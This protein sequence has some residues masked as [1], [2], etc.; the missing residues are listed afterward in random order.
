MKKR[1]ELIKKCSVVLL[2]LMIVYAVFTRIQWESEDEENVLLNLS[3]VTSIQIELEDE[4]FTFVKSEG[5]WKD[6]QDEAFPLSSSEMEWMEDVV[7]NLNVLKEFDAQEDQ[8]VYGLDAPQAVVTINESVTLKIGSETTDSGMYVSTGEDKVYVISKSDGSEFIKSRD[9][10]IQLNTIDGISETALESAS[11]TFD[12]VVYHF[13][14]EVKTIVDEETE[15]ESNVVIW[16][17]MKDE[18]KVEVSEEDADEIIA[19]LDKMTVDGWIDYDASEEELLNYGIN[20]KNI[21]QV[22]LTDSQIELWLGHVDENNEC[23]FIHRDTQ[24]VQL[25][26]AE[27]IDTMYSIVTSYFE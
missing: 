2:G 16:T 4:S 9:D 20:G 18:K 23:L 7:L 3:E 5:V 8:S 15:E 19:C 21:I 27:L 13:E 24:L 12:G 6:V 22:E 14:D 26:E 17:L 10:Y 11:F 25:L 1:I